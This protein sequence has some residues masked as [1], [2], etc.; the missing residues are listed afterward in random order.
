MREAAVASEHT[1]VGAG[2]QARQASGSDIILGAASQGVQIRTI[3]FT[4]CLYGQEEKE[5]VAA[6]ETPL[7]VFLLFFAHSFRKFYIL[8]PTPLYNRITTYSITTYRRNEYNEK[9]KCQE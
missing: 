8:L 5:E 4:R 6:Q 9:K 3:P 1:P 7:T 2:R